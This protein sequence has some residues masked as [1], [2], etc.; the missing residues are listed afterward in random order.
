MLELKNISKFYSNDRIVNKVLEDISMIFK[1]SSINTIVGNSGVGKTTLLNILGLIDSPTNGQLYFEDRLI[2]YNKELSKIRLNNY[3]YVFQKHCLM[4]EYS[5]LENL[6]LPNIFNN[7]SVK[8]AKNKAYRYLDKFN[9]LNIDKK[10]PESISAGECQRIAIIRSLMNEPKIVIA[11]EPTSNLDEENA[12]MIINFFSELN[13]K[14]KYM[15]IIATHDKRF[16]NISINNFKL[17]NKKLSKFN[18][19]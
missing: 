5:I 1:E 6:I 9:L 12:E 8:N 18:N 2:D 19:E 16:L 4:P 15:F 3:G 14:Y 17:I 10:Y 13:I 7:I 11:D